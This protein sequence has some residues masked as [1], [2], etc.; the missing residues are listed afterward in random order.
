MIV[1]TRQAG[2]A[3][4]GV[5]VADGFEEALAIA[6]SHNEGEVFVIG[7]AAI[8]EMAAPLAERLYLTRVHAEPAG[9]VYFPPVDPAAWRLLESQPHPADAKNQF[10]FTF[11]RYERVLP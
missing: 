5:E 7:G 4:P 9:D 2:Y 3:A 11:Q 6:K 10:P 1:I 8:F